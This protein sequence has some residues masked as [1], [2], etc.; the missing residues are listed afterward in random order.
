M[1]IECA[2]IFGIFVL[3]VIVFLRTHHKEWAFATL[4][5]TL[6]PLI[7]IVLE[8]VVIRMMNVNVT[9]FGGILTMVIAVAA[10]AAWIGVAEGFLKTKHKR[11]SVTYV[12]ICNAFN[13]AL[14]AI[15]INDIMT[16][17]GN[18]AIPAI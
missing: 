11:S 17:S 8:Y 7:Y 1:A 14:T 4:P 5:L 9:A 16:K 15:L 2:A 10:S 13:I 6:V 12:V 3:F 18:S